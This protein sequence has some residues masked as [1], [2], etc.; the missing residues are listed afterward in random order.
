MTDP[1]ED[2]NA[3]DG[4]VAEVAPVRR[5]RPII[6]W[7]MLGV[8]AIFLLTTAW[9]GWRTYQ[10]YR[11][12]QAAAVQVSA[13]QQEFADPSQ[14]GP[15]N[16]RPAII[17]DLQ[18]DA[19]S[20]RSAVD[21]PVYRLATGV[22]FVGPNLDAIRQV[23]LTVDTLASDVIPSLDSIARTLDPSA[24]AP[25]DGAVELAPIVAVAP[26]LQQADA[27]VQ[28]ARAE[29]AQIDRAAVVAPVGDAVAS[30]QRKLDS[31]ADLTEPTAR[32]ARMLPAALG[33]DGPRSY[34]VVFQNLAEPR[35]TG[36]IFGSYALVTADHGK[37]SMVDQGPARDLRYFTPPVSG[38]S[39]DQRRLFGPELVT[40]P[41]DVN[42]TP[43]FPTAAQLFVEMYQARGGG[44]VDGVLAVDPVA[45]AYL[46]KGSPA[47]NV[48]GVSVDADNVVATLLS[49]AYQQFDDASQEPRDRF[50]A[51]ATAAAFGQV[52]SGAADPESVVAGLR[53]AGTER[54]LL[55][56]S[57]HSDEQADLAA[58]GLSGA[59]DGST[60]ESSIGVFLNDAVGSKLGYYLTGRA[61]VSGG[62]CQ[63]DGSQLAAVA[64]T[65][66]YRPTPGLPAYVTGGSTDGAYRT[67]VLGNRSAC[68]PARTAAGP[69]ASRS[70]TCPPVPNPR[71]PSTCECH[72]GSLPRRWYTPPPS[73]TGRWPSTE[74]A[75]AAGDRARR[76]RP[77]RAP[78]GAP[79]LP[80]HPGSKMTTTGRTVRILV[81]SAG[82]RTYLLQWFRDSLE[83]WGYRAEVAITEAD[84][85]AVAT[86][87]ADAV[88][89]VPA[90]ADPGYVDAMVAVFDRVRPDLFLSVNDHE[91]TCLAGPV[92]D[93]LRGYGGVVL[94][95][96][97]D[98]QQVVADKYAMAR[99]FGALGIGCPTTVLGSDSDGLARLAASAARLVIKDRYGSGSSGFAVVRA[100]NVGAAIALHGGPHGRRD[101]DLLVV[102]PF[103][104]GVEFGLDIVGDLTDSA[105]VTAVLARRK[106]SASQGVTTRVVTVDPVGFHPLADRDRGVRAAGAGREPP[107]RR[108]VSVQSLRRQ[109]R[110]GLPDRGA[111]GPVR[112]GRLEHLP[113]R[114]HHRST[115]FVRVHRLTAFV[116]LRGHRR[117]RSRTRPGVSISSRPIPTC[118]FRSH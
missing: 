72:R 84:P 107:D 97:A 55:Y 11:D 61:D 69:W 40:F 42:L 19:A 50:L 63:A 52:M 76:L 2:T 103:L 10:A 21:D 101:P 30:L 13:L 44:P 51:A 75:G 31:A 3:A 20:A 27:T 25:R 74:S 49:T 83:R 79:I 90:Y 87:Y 48:E 56:Y 7:I 17:A 113:H 46:M 34:L 64:V 98:R 105:E 95:L 24:L 85:R 15:A 93:K 77:G 36:G 5:R 6:P 4:P 109:R 71:S 73:R 9:V 39:D 94:A 28:A 67:H 16:D 22:P 43:D 89:R 33:A 45:L 57:T 81:G 47:L 12:L 59:L 41:A 112:T 62:Q 111:A 26:Q 65:L 114:R 99:T 14:L 23:S 53:Q 106:E 58:T 70:S 91:L 68:G 110:P 60:E 96:D 102:Q 18:A 92:A 118:W 115:R 117:L 88:H 8:G 100:A 82:R 38:L 66:G 1:V 37:V 32:V 35:A 54:R 80:V 108:R 116:R 78:A 86:A 104:S 29:L